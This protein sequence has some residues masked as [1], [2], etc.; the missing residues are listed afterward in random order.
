MKKAS[1]R[2]L[3]WTM[4][5][6]TAALMATA[7]VVTSGDG[8]DDDSLFDGGEG[9]TS[10]TAGKTST[11]GGGK[12]GT[13][14]AGSTSGGSTSAGTSAGGSA[15]GG[16]GGTGG[17]PTE[18]V[19][20]CLDEEGADPQPTVLPSCAPDDKDATDDCRKCL[21]A[22]CCEEWRTCYGDEPRTACGWGADA[23]DD[24]EGQFD[25]VRSCYLEKLETTNDSED[26]IKYDCSFECLKQCDA[27]GLPLQ[28]TSD[29]L[30]C[31]TASCND[32]C[33]PPPM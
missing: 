8:D 11:G 15:T 31:A 33:F 13:S 14:T 10:S 17:T 30:D 25:C 22:S 2:V 27:D 29:V 9:G 1:Y 5:M 32:E 20:L 19:G 12:G 18:E 16:S 28:A 26:M 23:A 6:G 7:C 24:Y 21:R 3:Q 4:L